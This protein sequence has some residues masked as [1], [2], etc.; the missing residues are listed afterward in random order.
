MASIVLYV[1][2]VLAAVAIGQPAIAITVEGDYNEFTQ[3]AGEYNQPA[4]FPEDEEFSQQ[5][6]AEDK[7][8][9]DN[10]Q[11]TEAASYDSQYGL[12]PTKPGKSCRDIYQL[13][14]AS[15]GNSGYYVIL[16]NRPNFVYCDMKLECGGEK[17]WMR[18]ANVSAQ[19]SCPNGWSKITSPI[20]ACRPPSDNAGCYSVH[21]PTHGV[22]YRRVCG[23]AIGYQKGTPDAF[24]PGLD[25]VSINKPYLDGLSITYGNGLPRKHVWSYAVGFSENSKDRP[26]ICPC[27]RYRG[28]LPPS[29]VRDHYYCESGNTGGAQYGTYFTSDPLWDGYECYGGDNCC[30]QPN[31]PWFYRQI[32]LTSH[33]DLEARVCY[34][35]SFGD[36]GVLVKKL[37]LYVQ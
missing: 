7:N 4:A 5:A 23:M 15:H 32:P 17:G 29:F 36:E 37:Q 22:T 21:F 24:R 34:D 10:N 35:Q 31:M 28:Y 13:N 16:T 33:E 27:S 6:V 12:I 1:I 14:P 8:N 19:D 3:Q 20:T 2:V 11:Q 30:N 18:V 9:L 26:S 25:D